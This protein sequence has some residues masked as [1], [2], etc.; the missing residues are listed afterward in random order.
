MFYNPDSPGPGNYNIVDTFSVV[1]YTIGRGQ[2]VY[3]KSTTPGPGNYDPKLL[4]QSYCA[5]FGTQKKSISPFDE[6]NMG[7]AVYSPKFLN[8]KKNSESDSGKNQ[9]FLQSFSEREKKLKAGNYK[10]FQNN[11]KKSCIVSKSKK[12]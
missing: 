8:K 6:E 5:V 10:K 12:L 1:Q 7:T 2:R 11:S 3:Y 9:R 4:S